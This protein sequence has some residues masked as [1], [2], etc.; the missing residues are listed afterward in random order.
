MFDML[1]NSKARKEKK[2]RRALAEKLALEALDKFENGA[3]PSM[4]CPNC[5]KPIALTSNESFLLA[6]CPC[7]MCNV[8]LQRQT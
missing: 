4:S 1:F 7:E 2:Q 8:A 6:S 3:A 5:L